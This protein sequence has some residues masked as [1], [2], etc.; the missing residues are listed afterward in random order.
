MPFPLFASVENRAISH[1]AAS[2]RSDAQSSPVAIALRDKSARTASCVVVG[3]VPS[4]LKKRKACAPVSCQKTNDGIENPPQNGIESS[5]TESENNSI[6]DVQFSDMSVEDA[7]SDDEYDGAESNFEFEDSESSQDGFFRG[8]K[9]KISKDA[10]GCLDAAVALANENAGTLSVDELRIFFQKM[11]QMRLTLDTAE[12]LQH[13][14]WKT[15][16]A[17]FSKHSSEL[18]IEDLG[19]IIFVLGFTEPKLTSLVRKALERLSEMTPELRNASPKALDPLCYA[20]SRL[21]PY[22]HP[23]QIRTIHEKVIRDLPDFRAK[24]FFDVLCTLSYIQPFPRVGM[25]L[26]CWDRALELAPFAEVDALSPLL[27]AMVRIQP[28]PPK[29]L[30]DVVFERCL[31]AAPEMRSKCLAR[32]LHWVYQSKHEK[33]D[34]MVKA[35]EGYMVENIDDASKSTMHQWITAYAGLKHRKA[36]VIEVV[37]KKLLTFDGVS[38]NTLASALRLLVTSPRKN[39][40]LVIAV[41]DRACSVVHTAGSP[42]SVSYLQSLGDIGLDHR[43]SEKAFER[44]KNI[45][46]PLTPS[47][48]LRITIACGRLK[49]A[50]SGFKGL[51]DDL[52]SE[53]MLAT[54]DTQ[55]LVFMLDGLRKVGYRNKDVADRLS[56]AIEGNLYRLDLSSIL[57]A[58]KA[59]NL[60][61]GDSDILLPSAQKLLLE[62]LPVA[63]AQEISYSLEVVSC[64][65][66]STQID[67][68]IIATI[69]SGVKKY[70]MDFTPIELT[71]TIRWMGKSGYYEAELLVPLAN[72][73]EEKVH[74]LTSGQVSWI[75]WG[76]AKI[77]HVME[78]HQFDLLAGK[79]ILDLEE[80]HP[81]DVCRF[82]FAC[83]KMQYGDAAILQR[84]GDFIVT[85]DPMHL[86]FPGISII[87]WGFGK[88][89][90]RHEKLLMW[91]TEKTPPILHTASPQS[92]SNLMFTFRNFDY[93]PSEEFLEKVMQVS[94]SQ[95]KHF[96][97]F[98]LGVVTYTLVRFGTVLNP[99]FVSLASDYLEKRVKDFDGNGVSSL[100]WS[101]NKFGYIPSKTVVTNACHLVM[102][103]AHLIDLKQVGQFLWS[104]GRAGYKP[105]PL[106]EDIVGRVSRTARKM[107]TPAL[108]S[109]VRGFSMCQFLS[110]DM[111][112]EVRDGSFERL[113]E[114][115]PFDLSALLWGL[116]NLGYREQEF[117]KKAA[118]LSYQRAE[119]MN[120]TD[121]FT[122]IWAFARAERPAELFLAVARK[123]LA[124]GEM[125]ELKAYQL[126]SLSWALAKNGKYDEKLLDM[127]VVCI[128]DNIEDLNVKGIATVLWACATL[129]HDPGDLVARL[130]ARIGSP[131]LEKFPT[132]LSLTHTL[133]SCARLLH[134]PPPNVIS[135]GLEL[136]HRSQGEIRWKGG[137]RDRSKPGGAEARHLML[138]LWSLA[139]FGRH[140][141][142]LVEGLAARV[143]QVDIL[144]DMQEEQKQQIAQCLLAAN[145]DGTTSPLEQLPSHYIAEAMASWRT[146]IK[147]NAEQEPSLFHRNVTASLHSMGVKYTNKRVSEDRCMVL[148]IFVPPLTGSQAARQYKG[149]ALELYGPQ[150][151]TV[152]TGRRVGKVILRQKLLQD[153]GYRVVPLF[154]TEWQEVQGDAGKKETYLQGKLTNAGALQNDINLTTRPLRSSTLT[155]ETEEADPGA[156][157][158]ELEDDEFDDG[159]DDVES[160][161]ARAM[162]DYPL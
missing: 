1:F 22:V 24:S 32:T 113:E 98:E 107:P 33:A 96:K 156:F 129:S 114:F 122:V 46:Q 121:L 7:P 157:V 81:H 20:L 72:S 141:S 82:T 125:R 12:V 11:H 48:S 39:K 110:Q 38:A 67:K 85:H 69:L 158:D 91:I 118:L 149:V 99:T 60:M 126:V 63:P 8:R 61:G 150:H 56:K 41:S 64:L 119:E 161:S 162:V 103:N 136:L 94:G 34:V 31:E 116:S 21:Q 109:I 19:G 36:R 43:L 115:S 15:V 144:E 73:A 137:Q 77:G 58:M 123:R 135:A 25:A 71:R 42:V 2:S 83:A 160:A 45:D 18:S 44:I 23:V 57:L 28:S 87:G 128:E 51:V 132:W 152:N 3:R 84:V 154:Y 138:C 133:W 14:G 49:K 55:S 104:L 100:L 52:V 80:L 75:L 127:L 5:S 47:E 17:S 143:N 147:W 112:H 50:P 146:V 6:W 131:G 70:T 117:F 27:R 54:A 35:L 153:R 97:P 130:T 4:S 105:T 102:T 145:A 16:E 10:V 66:R 79:L 29:R 92:L 62:K 88:L 76:F 13:P 124:D 74:Q 101:L 151:L 106:M 139:V 95:I 142:E 59:C 65:S 40:S 134:R 86:K 108:A 53:R 89:N 93:V 111:L 90:F 159:E 155:L 68:E 120:A 37:V 9:L 30:E 78:R 26:V 148:D 140:K